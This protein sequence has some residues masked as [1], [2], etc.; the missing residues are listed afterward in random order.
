VAIRAIDPGS[1]TMLADLDLLLT[2]LFATADDLLPEQTKNARRSV[3]DAEIVT[4]TVAQ[5]VMNIAS[6]REFPAG[7]QPP[8]S[9]VREAAS[10]AGVPQAAFAVGQDDRVADSDLHAGQPRLPQHDPAAGLNTGGMPP[11]ASD[12]WPRRQRLRQ[13]G[14][15]ALRRHRAS[16]RA[17]DQARQ[18]AA[19]LLLDPPMH[20]VELLDA[21]K[22]TTASNATTRPATTPRAPRAPPTRS[23]SPPPSDSTTT[24]PNPHAPTPT[25]P[26]NATRNPSP[27][28]LRRRR[29]PPSAAPRATGAARARV[30]RRPCG[31]PRCRRAGAR[32]GGC[33]GR[34]SARRS[35]APRRCRS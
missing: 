12:H 34:C 32:A 23:R 16:P 14:C 11:F 2:A 15:R 10:A 1:A 7:P 18:P 9:P 31:R 21:Q 3:T 5:A 19:P 24:P 35:G 22:T 26:P 4:L 33:S 6:D 8:A 17:Q 30:R 20:R 25:T 27:S 28:R 13:H 29:R